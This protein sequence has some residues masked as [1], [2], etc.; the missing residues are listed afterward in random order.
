MLTWK[1]WILRRERRNGCLT[2]RRRGMILLLGRKLNSVIRIAYVLKK[3]TGVQK[4]PKD[5]IRLKQWLGAIRRD[6]FTPT[7]NSLMCKNH[8]NKDD[9]ELPKDLVLG[10]PAL[11]SAPALSRADAEVFS[12]KLH[13]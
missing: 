13:Q 10:K 3:K 6:Q 12:E 11:E 1:Q 2:S 4:Y 9:Y 7:N 8:F 5:K